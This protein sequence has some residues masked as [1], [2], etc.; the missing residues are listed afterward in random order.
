MAWDAAGEL[1]ARFSE[2]F[3]ELISRIRLDVADI[4]LRS[5]AT[6][7]MT[8]VF[9]HP[10]DRPFMSR[11]GDVV[12]G[13]GGRLCRVHLRPEPSILERRVLEASRG[14]LGKLQD[15]EG[16]RGALKRWDAYTPVDP[17]D[18]SVDNSELSATEAAAMIQDHY[19]L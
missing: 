15:L 10:E 19:R 3:N 14:G 18:L 16:L 7:I 9:A 2:P 13:A 8:M 12:R 17:S 5:G 11:V 6:L 1:F 4:S